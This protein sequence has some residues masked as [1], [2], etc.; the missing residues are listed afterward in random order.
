MNCTLYMVNV[1]LMIFVSIFIIVFGPLS[2]FVAGQIFN[3][4]ALPEMNVIWI[5]QTISKILDIN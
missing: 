4:C 2:A 5:G 3:T 1:Y